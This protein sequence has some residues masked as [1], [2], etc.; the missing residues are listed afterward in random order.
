MVDKRVSTSNMLIYAFIA[1]IAFLCLLPMWLLVTT[2]LMNARELAKEGVKLFPR[3]IS[4]E[5]YRVLLY[6]GIN[7]LG[8]AYYVTF[9]STLLGTVM[10]LLITASAGYALSSPMLKGAGSISLYFY[11]TML[12]SGGMVPWYLINYKLGVF[13]N[14]F[15]L[16]IPSLLFNPFNLFLVRNFMKQLPVSLGE[17]ARMD[18]ASEYMIAWRIYLPLSAPVLATITLFYGLGYWNSWWNAIMLIEDQTLFPLQYLLVRIRSSLAAM[19]L[20]NISGGAER[21]P[22]IPV[23]NA[24][25]LVT[26]GPIILLYPFLQRF[27]IKGIVIG[28]VKG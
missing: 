8:T 15:A 20:S 6:G 25:T 28:A 5:A 4:F 22:T 3:H 10:A 16:V 19:R 1:T 26:I 21:P 27:F 9:L 2:S 17:S 12:F 7:T 14:F 23:Q 11:I 13:N 24:V 18:G